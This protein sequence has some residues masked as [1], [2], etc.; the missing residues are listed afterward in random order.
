M[1]IIS[2]FVNIYISLYFL[3]DQKKPV[4]IE[5]ENVAMDAYDKSEHV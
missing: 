2:H 4:I 5:C 1:Y 3:W